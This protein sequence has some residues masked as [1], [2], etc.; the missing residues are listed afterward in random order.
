MTSKDAIDRIMKMLS[1]NQQQIAETIATLQVEN[2]ML[3][4]ENDQL[5]GDHADLWKIMI[6]ILHACPGKEMRIHNT[7]FLRYDEAYRMV[8]T[9][10]NKTEEVVL[11]LVVKDDNP[12]PKS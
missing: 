12:K 2:R 6:T 11:S 8:R 9:Y 5:K 4:V 7:Q 10:D 1:P 3:A